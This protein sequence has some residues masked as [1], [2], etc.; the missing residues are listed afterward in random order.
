[1]CLVRQAFVVTR[2]L[3]LGVVD[4]YDGRAGMIGVLT[5]RSTEAGRVGEKEICD[6]QLLHTSR[7][8]RRPLWLNGW[9]AAK[10]FDE[11]HLKRFQ[12]FEGF[13]VSGR[14]HGKSMCSVRSNVSDYAFGPCQILLRPQSPSPC[15]TRCNR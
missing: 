13:F 12:D 5:P 7:E 15:R 3:Q 6:L 1:M 4:F 8:D 2:G 11:D 14:I 9:I 10:K